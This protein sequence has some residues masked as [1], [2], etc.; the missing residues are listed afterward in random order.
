[1]SLCK[2]Q[3]HDPERSVC[4][5]AQRNASFLGNAF[6]LLKH[7]FSEWLED[8]A[9]QLGAALAYYTVFSLAPLVV[10][11]LAIVGVIFRD[12]PRGAWDRITQEMSYFLDP[13][14]VQVVQNIAQTASQPGESTTATIIGV[15]L[16]LFGAS[17]VFGQLQD[18]LNTIWGVKAKPSAG[19]WGWLRNRFLSFAMVIAYARGSVP[20]VIDEGQT[21]FIA[22]DRDEAVEAVCRR[23]IGEL[24][25]VFLKSA[26][27]RA[28]WR[29]IT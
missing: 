20:E 26:S 15:A 22:N 25:G 3:T 17:G 21:G 16:A 4:V 24:V 14:G 8:K 7:T 6:S 5:A 11:L 18:A 1:M 29:T 23:S 10:V 12:D 13:S 2:N 19:I 27:R 28:A 9:P